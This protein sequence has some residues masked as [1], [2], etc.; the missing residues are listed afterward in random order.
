MFDYNFPTLDFPKP[1]LTSF[2]FL[3]VLHAET[4]IISVSPLIEKSN[5]EMFYLP[6]PI[7]LFK[8]LSTSDGLFFIRYTPEDTFK[9]KWFL[10]QINP[11]KIAILNMQRETA[12]NYHITFLE[13]DPA[14]KHL[15]DNK[16]RW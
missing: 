3:L 7:V 10:V 8:S 1:Q 9:Q 5:T 15:Y 16:A 12:A 2:T 4:E 13:Q 6:S 11:E 14:N